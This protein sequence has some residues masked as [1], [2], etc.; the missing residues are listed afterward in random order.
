[1]AG[2]PAQAESG[3]FPRIIAAIGGATFLLF[4][5]WAMVAP[6]SFYESVALFEPYN[7][8]F[9]Q[10]LGAFQIGLGATLVLAAFISSDAL[11]AGLIG[12][13]VGASAH[14]VSHLVGLDAGGS[15]AFD[16]PA[17]SILGVL[18]VTGGVMR[19]HRLRG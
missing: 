11:V 4:G 9:V 16:I 14:V 12:V 18:L 19:W 8:H 15:P 17:L 6:G 10:D 1:M 5:F 7:A 3:G 2:S 13:G